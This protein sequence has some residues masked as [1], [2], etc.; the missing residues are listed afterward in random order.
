MASSSTHNLP[1]LIDLHGQSAMNNKILRGTRNTTTV[2]NL[3]ENFGADA[4]MGQNSFLGYLDRHGYPSC[5]HGA[6]SQANHMIFTTTPIIPQR[7]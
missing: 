5:I 3:V 7:H 4:L 6:C 2:K 1:L